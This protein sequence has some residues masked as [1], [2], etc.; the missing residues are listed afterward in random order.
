[1]LMIPRSISWLDT[2]SFS[3]LLRYWSRLAVA[4]TMFPCVCS[5]NVNSIFVRTS[6]NWMA[7]GSIA[8]S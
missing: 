6:E 1:M 2:F 5:R 7:N 4:M 3:A 8:P